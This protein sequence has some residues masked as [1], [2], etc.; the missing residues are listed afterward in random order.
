MGKRHLL[1]EPSHSTS[2]GERVCPGRVWTP[3]SVWK[4]GGNQVLW[5]DQNDALF[6]LSLP[7]DLAPP[8]ISIRGSGS[9]SDWGENIIVKVPGAVEG[10]LFFDGNGVSQDVDLTEF[11]LPMPILTQPGGSHG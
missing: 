2:F 8:Q 1:P 6:L 9:H 4:K 10:D 7:I 5:T 11:F 3:V